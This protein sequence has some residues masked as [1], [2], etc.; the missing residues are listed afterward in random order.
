MKEI[1]IIR[2]GETDLNKRGI[3]QGRGIDSDLNQ[4]GINQANAF[5]N[6]YKHIK[7]D[8]IYVSNLKRTQQ[9]VQK[10]ID[11][12]I[13]YT[14]LSGLDELAWGIWEGQPVTEKS[15]QAFKEIAE[16]WLNGNYDA[17]FDLGES[18]NE[19]SIRL[20]DALFK[21]LSNK[22]EERILVCMHGRALRLFLC[23][24]EKKPLSSMIDYPHKNTTLYKL[25]YDGKSFKIVD[26]NSTTH[27][28]LI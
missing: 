23:L 15:Q 7:F 19:V 13:A 11:N 25:L 24:L 9:T 20:Q 10:F 26:F 21:I 1:Y 28:D 12:G 22:N 5:Y 27:L 2:H 18:P 17:K 4:T 14:K 6:T 8:H 16:K 3:V